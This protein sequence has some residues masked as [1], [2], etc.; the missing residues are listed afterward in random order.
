MALQNLFKGLFLDSGST[1]RS[2]YF[3][4]NATFHF[5]FKMFLLLYW[6]SI[7]SPKKHCQLCISLSSKMI[8]C[9]KLKSPQNANAN[10]TT[11]PWWGNKDNSNKMFPDGLDIIMFFMSSKQGR[12]PKLDKLVKSHFGEHLAA[13]SSEAWDG[14]CIVPGVPHIK[15]NLLSS[16]SAL[17]KWCRAEG[18]DGLCSLLCLNHLYS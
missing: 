9:L 16:C 6:V 14:R 17:V 10:H 3:M 2:V 4:F 11:G 5:K 12:H 7:K 8:N 15:Q 13:S 1:G 18:W